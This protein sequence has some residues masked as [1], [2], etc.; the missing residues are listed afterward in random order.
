MVTL[1]FDLV[2]S[3]TIGGDLHEDGELRWNAAWFHLAR[4]V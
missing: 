1:P 4:G 3:F 2:S